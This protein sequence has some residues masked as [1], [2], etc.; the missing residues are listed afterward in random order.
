MATNYVATP[1]EGMS[2]SQQVGDN[3][4]VWNPFA[5]PTFVLN[6]VLYLYQIPNF[7]V[8]TGFFI[9][10]PILDSG[11]SLTIDVGDNVTS[12]NGGSNANG[13]FT[14]S[15]IGRNATNG[16]NCLSPGNVSGFVQA[17]IPKTYSILNSNIPTPG[18]ALGTTATGAP[19]GIWLTMKIHAAAQTATTTGSIY[20]YVR[21]QSLTS[22]A[23]L[24]NPAL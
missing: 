4:G 8:L 14:Q 7:V 2:V 6:D 18:T 9:S 10:L 12:T 3:V 1:W 24:T 11:T 5:N 21:Y 22:T 23:G 20:G 17:S 13:Y 19:G 16:Q 15:Q